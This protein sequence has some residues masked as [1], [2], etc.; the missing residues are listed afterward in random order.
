M[1]QP[2]LLIL[3]RVEVRGALQQQQTRHLGV[4]LPDL[5]AVA[6]VAGIMVL[7]RRSFH[8]QKVI[9]PSPIRMLAPPEFTAF[10]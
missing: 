2:L 3:L 7:P 4:D 1:K 6:V 9:G 8:W 10:L 5:G